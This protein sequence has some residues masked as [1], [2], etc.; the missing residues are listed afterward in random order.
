MEQTEQEMLNKIKHRN[1]KVMD[2][3]IKIEVLVDL[4]EEKNKKIE[5]LENENQF[6][7]EVLY[8]GNVDY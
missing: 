7:K 2:Y 1:Y 6:L 4:V 8:G 3:L 5:K